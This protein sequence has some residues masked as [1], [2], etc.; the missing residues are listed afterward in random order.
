MLVPQLPLASIEFVDGSG[1]LAHM[2]IRLKSEV[3]AASALDALAA[4]AATIAPMT[5]C[6]ITA[7]MVRYY[8]LADPRTPPPGTERASTTGALIFDCADEGEYA[9]LRVPAINSDFVRVDGAGAGVLLDVDS[10]PL[11]ALID[12]LVDGL[13]CNPFASDI[14]ELSAAYVQLVP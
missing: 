7:I 12:L 11:A 1:N 9:I 14:V 3:T 2:Q 6:A 4:L 5:D 8:R 10:A 13:A